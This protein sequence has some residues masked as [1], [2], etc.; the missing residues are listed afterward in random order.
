MIRSLLAECELIH[1]GNEAG[2]GCGGIGDMWGYVLNWDPQF[3]SGRE[4]LVSL[5][6]VR[7]EAWSGCIWAARFSALENVG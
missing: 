2:G 7:R 5:S 3:M 4:R 6:I 1:T